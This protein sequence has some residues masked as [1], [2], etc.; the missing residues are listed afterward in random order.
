[1]SAVLNINLDNKFEDVALIILI[2]NKF[3]DVALI[4]LIALL[5]R[6]W[7]FNNINKLRNSA[8]QSEEIIFILC[9]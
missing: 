5:R 6:L 3:E 7:M 8:L 1:M 9:K 4:I 2:I